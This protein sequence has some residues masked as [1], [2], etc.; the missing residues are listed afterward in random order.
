MIPIMHKLRVEAVFVLK[1]QIVARKSKNGSIKH[2]ETLSG[3]KLAIG[4]G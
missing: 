2:C 4:R 3:V 1:R